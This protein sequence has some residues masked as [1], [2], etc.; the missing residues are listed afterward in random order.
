MGLLDSNTIDPRYAGLLAA[1]FGML[2]A[3]GPSRMPV[4]LG[5]AI[6]QGGQSGLGAY[7]SAMQLK[8]MDDYRRAQEAHLKAQTDDLVRKGDLSEQL[9]REVGLL[10]PKAGAPA[11]PGGGL[12]AP[13]VAPQPQ[14]PG[15]LN[16]GAQ[17]EGASPG[18]GS[19]VPPAA[20]MANSPLSN[21]PT[22][23]RQAMGLNAA[24]PG[25]GLGG[26][27][28]QANTPIAG[29]EGGLY[30]VGPDGKRHLSE[31]FVEGEETR[32]RLKNRVENENAVVEVKMPDGSTR[33]MTKAQELELTRPENT[34]QLLSQED[35]GVI[36]NDMRRSGLKSANVSMQYPGALVKGAIGD[37]GGFTAG[38]TTFSAAQASRRGAEDAKAESTAF[39][40]AKAATQGK[41][42]ITALRQYSQNFTPSALAPFKQ[43]MGEWLIGLGAPADKV[44]EKLGSIGDMQAAQKVAFSIATQLTKQ[45]SSRPSQLEWTSILRNATPNVALTGGGFEA[46]MSKLETD[47]D[48]RIGLAQAW[49]DR[50]K[51]SQQTF[52]EFETD[53]NRQ[54]LAKI[55][56]NPAAATGKSG[57]E[58]FDALPRATPANKGQ[59]IRDRQTGKIL[60]SNGMSWVSE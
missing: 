6:G 42:D 4:S 47:Y 21:L 41:S 15:L 46:V 14:Q 2:N 49:A 52:R 16:A 36:E 53:Y 34:A 56:E 54:Y 1:G 24:I 8:I 48:R 57:G 18:G 39:D 17:P 9:L 26:I 60:K 51:D 7:Q 59:R 22:Y 45:I 35:R 12:L 33:R 31:G 43:K 50:P 38:Q 23:A 27:V 20:P 55:A 11:A 29:R 13:Q 30:D 25:A 19:L 10:P 28:M 37:P 3:S 58:S 32:L 40:E 44:G 5:Q